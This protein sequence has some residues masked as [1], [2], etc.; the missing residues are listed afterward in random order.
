MKAIGAL[1]VASTLTLTGGALGFI[2]LVTLAGSAASASNSPVLADPSEEAVADI[3]PILLQLFR[4]EAQRCEGLP[5]TVMAAISKVESNHGRY[6]G[7]TIGA[8]GVARP[9]IIGIAL[10]GHNGTARI[11]DTDNGRWDRD[12]VWD[13]A[14]GPFQFIPAS[15]QIFGSDGNGD[16]V[17]DPHNVYDAVPAMR[18][19]LCPDGRI[20]NVNAAILAYNHSQDYVDAV[21][22]WAQTYTGKRFSAIQPIAG[23]AL[24]V[25]PELVDDSRLTRPHHDYPAW[26]LGLSVGTPVYAMTAGTITMASTAGIYPNDPNRCGNTVTL[27]GIDGAT[28]T[29]CHLSQLAVHVGRIVGAGTLIGL[30]GGQPGAPGAGNTTDPHL[31]LGIRINDTSVCPQPLLLAT[32]RRTPI[33]PTAAP[34]AGCISGRTTTN[35]TTWLDA[36][37]ITQSA[38]LDE[39][40]P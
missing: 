6:G 4:D 28:Y 34:T 20:V 13:R 25:S 5:W 22:E 14:V 24:P 12:L 40:Q 23:Y 38:P 17:A 2:G 26:D 9:L 3:P 30:S 36:T 32:A 29:Y 15:W 8:D 37:G 39:A 33:S 27:A 7:A 11:A 21:L 16:G 18:R 19:H 1:A 31:H 35:W 10:D